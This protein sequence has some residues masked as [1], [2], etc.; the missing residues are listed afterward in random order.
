MRTGFELWRDHLLVLKGEL[1][2]D[3]E[4]KE[5]ISKKQEYAKQCSEIYHQHLRKKGYSECTYCGKM[6]TRTLASECSDGHIS[7]FTKTTL[8]NAELW[9]ELRGKHFCNKECLYRFFNSNE[10]LK[11]LN[12]YWINYSDF[13]WKKME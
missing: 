5:Y 6:C 10:E 9:M 1:K 2:A 3:E 12:R 8:R 11:P 7:I 4:L 13:F